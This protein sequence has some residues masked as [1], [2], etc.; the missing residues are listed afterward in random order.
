MAIMRRA[1]WRIAL[2][3]AVFNGAPAQPPPADNQTHIFYGEVLAV[4]PAAKT[5]TIKSNGRPLVFHYTE[6]TKISSPHR[7]VT[8]ESIR[9]GQGAGVIMRLGPGNIGIAE[10]VRFEEDASR[11]KDLSLYRAVT[12]AGETVTGMAV[13][14][15]VVHEPRSDK[16]ARA[17]EFGTNAAAGVFVMTVRPDGTVAEVTAA[18]S[19]PYAEFNQRAA[20]WL[21]NWRFRPGSVVKVQMPVVYVKAFQ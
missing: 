1:G 11:A 6:K 4:D 10:R 13:G 7:H 5:F 9:P 21:K 17:A 15:Y 8:W 14:N 18:K 16:F 2:L 19:M 12:T 20:A 3:C